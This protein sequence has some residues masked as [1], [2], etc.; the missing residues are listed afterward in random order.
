MHRAR[1]FS[2]LLVMAVTAP[3][4]AY[5][6]E[7]GETA[8]SIVSATQQGWRLRHYDNR[9]GLSH[10]S[11][12]CI[13][14]D[15]KGFIWFGTKNGLNRFDG[16]TFKTY[17]Y[18]GKPGSLRSSIIYDIVEDDESRMWVATADGVFLFFP[19]EDLF[20]RFEEVVAS[21]ITLSDIVWH[22]KKDSDGCIWI[23][24]Q[25]GVYTYYNRVITDLTE[26]IRQ[27]M[28][29][30]PENMFIEGSTAYFGNIEGKVICCDRFCGRILTVA[31]IPSSIWTIGEFGS[32]KLLVGT[33]QK[34]LFVV[35]A[36][37]DTAYQI[38]VGEEKVLNHTGLFVHSVCKV[39]EQEY[40]VGSESGL[41]LVKDDRMAPFPRNQILSG[42]LQDDVPRALL[43]DSHGNV[44]AGN[45]FGGVDCFHPNHSPFR[46]YHSSKSD[47]GCG[48]RIDCFIEDSY[49]RVWVGTEDNGLCSFDLQTGLLMPASSLSDEPLAGFS[50]QCLALM[51]DDELLIGS[52]TEG[53]YKLNLHT[54][55]LS[56]IVTDTDVY[57][58]YVDSKGDVWAG[59]HSELCLYNKLTKT[60]EVYKPEV[61]TFT[62][63]I[64]EDKKGN[65]W[66]VAMNQVCRIN[67]QDRH[68]KR[69]AFDKEGLSSDYHGCAVT[70]LCDSKGRVWFGFEEGGL[71]LFNEQKET[72]EKVTPTRPSVGNGVYSIVED[73]KGLLWLGTN[74]GLVLFDPDNRRIVDTYNMSDGLPTQQINYRAGLALRSGEL[75]FGTTEGFFTFDP[76]AIL[77]DKVFDGITF[78]DFSVGDQHVD[79]CYVDTIL[80]NHD[81]STF[82]LSFSTLNYASEGIARVAYQ[83]KGF[84]KGWNVQNDINRVSYHN[85]PPGRYTFCIHTIPSSSGKDSIGEGGEMASI[86]IHIRPVWYQTM[87]VRSLMIVVLMTMS[88]LG[89]RAIVRNKRRNIMAE[90]AEKEKAIEQQLYKAKIDFFTHLA[91]EIRTPASLI[92]DPIHRLR[93]RGLPSD[94]DST[95][96]IVE[97]NAEELNTLITE[98]LD[99][100]KLEEVDTTITPRPVD[101]KM[102]VQ[103]T[104]SRYALFATDKGLRTSFSLPEGAVM[105][106]IDAK[107]TEK[108]L[109]NLF[110]NA[111]KYA[112][113][114]IRLTLVSDMEQE[115]ATFAVCNDGLRIPAEMQE[116]IFEPF[117]QV[118]HVSMATQGSGI[119]LALASTLSKL[120]NGMLMLNAQAADNEFDL[121][122]P[123]A[124]P[125]V[126][127]PAEAELPQPEPHDELPVSPSSL[128]TTSR[129]VV[130]VVEDSRD[131]RAYLT[132]VLN[133]EFEVME[134]SDGLY[135][136][137]ILATH[138][139]QLVVT[140]VMMPRKDGFELC[141][142]IKSSADYCHL[143]VVIL[144]AKDMLDDRISGL[145]YGADAYIPKPFSTEYLLA[146]IR[147]LLDNRLRL[148]NKYAHSV[149]A[150]AQL[151]VQSK[152]DQ[153]FLEK[154]TREVIAHITVETFTIDDLSEALA[155]SRSTLSRK[156]KAITGQT[157][158]DFITLVRLK[159]AAELLREGSYRVNEVC[160]M[161]GFNSSHHFTSIFKK[162]FGITPGAYAAS[163]KNG[164]QA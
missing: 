128:P 76:S 22:L 49:H 150:D 34:G 60:F 134:A 53:I 116:K 95:L 143:P 79:I 101:L 145:E 71:C 118:P 153:E 17:I 11:V 73:Q 126:A 112:S 135:A 121:L 132:S 54:G 133:E 89:F 98:L 103:E 48:R 123:L 81:Q 6:A 15:S 59:I 43:C 51:P 72:L 64:F 105:T 12:K 63:C 129:S 20:R 160:M 148:Q 68:M 74:N 161:V 106:H 125:D 2:L 65:I 94:V 37:Q 99:F 92:K 114:Y 18:D 107:A 97:R 45:Y 75:M 162:Q 61:G 39:S 122:L 26:K 102:L 38:P 67:L 138:E 144:T 130:L 56:H 10:N 16:Q 31:T 35:D 142:D 163:V 13:Y 70:G 113:T 86:R 44:W 164:V 84:D 3:L 4:S 115:L 25:N 24:T 140:D 109:N 156:I 88:L 151:P 14:E 87:L 28:P 152:A 83:L 82:T 100:R 149:D 104:W 155:M 127:L 77:H 9:D 147:N 146:Q 93:K 159:K 139:V 27:Y 66:A 158:G 137:D 108:I 23:L 1:L 111:V 62:H 5:A 55:S 57:S 69:Y 131:M 91:H 33:Q 50:V 7:N 110:S 80:L 46:C 120:Q 85:V 58:L 90:Q 78:T 41:L 47:V 52:T 157:P 29:K 136:L 124:G 119:G 21:D 8:T 42:T 117:V 141:R 32:D 40:W 36:K 19:A 154:I 30:L 96:A